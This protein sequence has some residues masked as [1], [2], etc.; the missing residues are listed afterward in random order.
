MSGDHRQ[1]DYAIDPLFTARWS[2]RAFTEEAIS[3]DLVMSLFEAARWAPS[4]KNAQPWRF[5]YALRDDADWTL[6]QG[7]LFERNR[8]WANRAGALI[9]ILSKRVH[10]EE[11]GV[12]S[13]WRTHAFDTGAAWSN[14]ALQASRLGLNVR[15]M[16]GFDRE[17]AELALAVPDDHDIH[18][19]VAVGRPGAAADLPSHLQPLETPTPRRPLSEIVTQGRFRR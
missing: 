5:L 4:A 7:L 1:P 18:V 16:G 8:I 17:R 2:R 3:T 11:D 13:P 12:V 9:A 14:L 15:A 19:L 10:E 6:F